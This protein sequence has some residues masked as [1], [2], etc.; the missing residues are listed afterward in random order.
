MRVPFFSTFTLLGSFLCIPGQKPDMLRLYSG[1]WK[2]ERE[3]RQA[4]VAHPESGS[5]AFFGVDFCELAGTACGGMIMPEGILK[6]FCRRAQRGKTFVAFP[7]GLKATPECQLGQV[8]YAFR[9]A[10]NR[11]DF[12]ER[13]T[14]ISGRHLNSKGR[15]S[16]PFRMYSQVAICIFS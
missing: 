6:E 8:H 4:P 14:G 12:G 2:T 5:L 1:I 11:A 10:P 15:Q 9:S 13:E 16:L 3:R 7:L